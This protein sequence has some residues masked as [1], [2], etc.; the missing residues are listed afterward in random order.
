M[1]YLELHKLIKVIEN[2]PLYF[3]CTAVTLFI[4]FSIFGGG[5]LG[6]VT[7]T[8]IY[9]VSVIVAVFQGD[10]ILRFVM[11]VRPLETKREKE[12]LLPLFEEVI[13]EAGE[14]NPEVKYIE[15]CIIDSVSINACAIGTQ[16]IAITKGAMKTFSADELKAI[17]AH[18]IGHIVSGDTMASLL[19]IIGNGLFTIGIVLCKLIL[20]AFHSVGIGVQ[21]DAGKTSPYAKIIIGLFKIILFAF[22]F[23]INFFIAINSRKNE[24][25]A[26]R[27][28][29]SLGYGDEMVSALYLIEDIVLSGDRKIIDKLVASHPITAKRI[30]ALEWLIDSEE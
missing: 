17:I 23:I 28:V 20:F 26:D 18:E 15:L 19:F 6:T 4:S 27:Y 2:N 10:R 21:G 22:S 12:Y 13:W 11:N 1:H 25:R 5:L 3:L 30:G 24:Y 14:Q 9:T 29:H 16:T 8:I 7:V